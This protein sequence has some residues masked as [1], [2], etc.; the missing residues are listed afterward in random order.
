MKLHVRCKTPEE[1]CI[2]FIV[3]KKGEQIGVCDKCWSKIADKD[4]ETGKGPKPTMEEVLSDK[5]RF[6]DNPIETEY[7][8][9]GATKDAET[10]EKEEEID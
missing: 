5:N 1:P 2:V 6:G 10:D 3:W 4:W 8:F 7:K 9:R